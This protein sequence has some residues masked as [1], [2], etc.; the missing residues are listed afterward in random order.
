MILLVDNYDS[1]VYNLARYFQRLGQTTKVVRNDQLGG[2]LVERLNPAA[3][4]FSPGPGTPS[5]AGDSLA[6][7]QTFRH[8]LPMLGVCLGHQT[9][10]AAWG[11]RIVRAPEPRHGRT[12]PIEHTGQG[13]FAGL[14]NPMAACRYHSLVVDETTLSPEFQ[15]TARSADDR[16]VMAIRHRELPIVGWQFHPESVLTDLGY[17]LIAAFLSR[18]G[19]TSA[20]QTPTIDD[21]R[22]PPPAPATGVP[23]IPI[24]F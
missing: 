20:E 18:A 24:T 1:F 15:V 5:E 17:Q 3:I 9:L 6:L 7:V 23:H 11:A 10:A 8:R 4:V 13:V 12:S 2:D 22:T 19:L 16:Q 14:A 21:E